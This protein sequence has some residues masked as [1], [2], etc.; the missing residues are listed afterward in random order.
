MEPFVN[1]SSVLEISINAVR[2]SSVV[3]NVP[4]AAAVEALRRRCAAVGGGG[5]TGGK[6]GAGR[7]GDRT[8]ERV[9]GEERGGG[10]RE[11]RRNEVNDHLKSTREKL[12][13]EER[14]AV[15]ASLRCGGRDLSR[16]LRA[17]R[18]KGSRGSK[19]DDRE[20]RG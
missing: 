3:A 6:R 18:A 11:G 13:E 17:T 19:S 8:E 15:V 20:M 2:S 7:G 1:P 4:S 12:Q 10:T 14:A 16:G 5:S 9:D